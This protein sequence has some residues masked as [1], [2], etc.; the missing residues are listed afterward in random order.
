MEKA[1]AGVDRRTDISGEE[2]KEVQKGKIC[3]SCWNKKD[4]TERRDSMEATILETALSQG[5]WAAHRTAATWW[6]T[7]TSIS[8]PSPALQE[9]A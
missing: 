2:G 8:A 1:A 4:G 9:T 7:A 6:T 3:K 5:I